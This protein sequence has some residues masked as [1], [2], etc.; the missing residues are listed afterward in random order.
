MLNR[1]QFLAKSANSLPAYLA[2]GCVLSGSLVG[3]ERRPDSQV[4]DPSTRRHVPLKIAMQGSVDEAKAIQRAW[5]AASELPLEFELTDLE[6]MADASEA[7]A[8]INSGKRCD[9]IIYPIAIQSDAVMD[10]AV[11]VFSESD[12]QAF[13]ATAGELFRALRNVTRFAG[14][15]Y[16]VPLSGRLPALLSTRNTDSIQT[17][18]DYD[19]WISDELS[20]KASEPSTSGWAAAMF[21]WRANSVVQSG[22]LFD[23]E[24]LRPL[25]DEDPYV[26]VLD[27]MKTTASRYS[28]H[29]MSPEEIWNALRRGDL[30][31]GIGF[32]YG[33]AIDGITFDK[34]PSGPAGQ[35]V[36]LDSFTPVISLSAGCRQS[37]AAKQFIA[38]LCGGEG[39]VS[40]RRQVNDFTVTRR[41]PAGSMSDGSL[42]TVNTYGQW[43][44]ERLSTST[45][46]PLL[47]IH[48]ASSYY[49]SLDRAVGQCLDGK[50][51][52]AQ[53]LRDAAMRWDAITREVGVD[54]QLRAWRRSQGM[55]A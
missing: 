11:I 28:S 1:R 25:I 51:T 6:R 52:P 30:K 34:L 20:G 27:Q 9:V 40:V 32:P 38:W 5:E 7:A 3:C 12:L 29:R 48:R 45:T 24:E 46:R 23:R 17:W 14:V 19:R 55:R 54:K 21:L 15:A 47:E 43:L 44:Q 18:S 22:W 50:V 37:A 49:G 33:E 8:F 31:G 39:S 16:T 2:S 42:S 10:E 13:A 35:R 26:E 41:P 36:L 4:S 53:A